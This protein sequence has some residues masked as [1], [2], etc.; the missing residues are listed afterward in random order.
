MFC[1]AFVL[2]SC[3]VSAWLSAMRVYSGGKLAGGYA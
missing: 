2:R 3:S 1:A